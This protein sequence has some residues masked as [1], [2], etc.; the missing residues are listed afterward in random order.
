MSAG[1]ALAGTSSTAAVLVNPG[2]GAVFAKSS[3][4][5]PRFSVE[6]INV[7]HFPLNRYA[8]SAALRTMCPAVVSWREGDRLPCDSGL[9]MRSSAVS[10]WFFMVPVTKRSV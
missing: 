9:G 4:L 6:R 5:P 10:F 3:K 1:H 8:P 7:E 2:F